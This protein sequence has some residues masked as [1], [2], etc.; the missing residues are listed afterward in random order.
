M[1]DFF[2]SSHEIVEPGIKVENDE[3]PEL[4]VILEDGEKLRQALKWG[5][6][7]GEIRL[8]ERH[9]L[10]GALEWEWQLYGGDVRGIITPD[11]GV[12]IRDTPVNAET[13]TVVE[14]LSTVY[15]DAQTDKENAELLAAE[16]SDLEERLHKDSLVT[17][18]RG[19]GKAA[20]GGI[21]GAIPLM[22]PG[23]GLSPAIAVGFGASTIAWGASD[24]IRGFLR[25]RKLKDDYDQFEA[26]K[27]VEEL[28]EEAATWFDQLRPLVDQA[29]QELTEQPTDLV[30]RDGTYE[31]RIRHIVQR[32]KLPGGPKYKD[33]RL[34]VDGLRDKARGK[35]YIFHPASEVP[36]LLRNTEGSLW[37]NGK[38]FIEIIADAQAMIA[39][40]YAKLTELPQARRE[41]PG[42][43]FDTFKDQLNRDLTRLEQVIELA[44]LDLYRMRAEQDTSWQTAFADPIPN[45]YVPELPV[46]ADQQD[47]TIYLRYGQPDS[48]DSEFQNQR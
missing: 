37:Q 47:T 46:L 8:D 43:D 39:V 35:I 36:E 21:A 23:L 29:C 16:K 4:R 28:P 1:T 40:K 15:K 6:R 25:S 7:N 41:N 44:M 34:V 14:A 30:V 13:I 26:E 33:Y 24:G 9:V 5:V 12:I 48:A 19:L 11:H 3:D 32:L 45:P 10:E 17:R 38:Q 42:I 18:I 27:A 22:A 2:P 31:A 20:I